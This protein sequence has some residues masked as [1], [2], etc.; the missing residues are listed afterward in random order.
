[1]AIGQRQ[2]ERSHVEQAWNLIRQ[3]AGALIL[4]R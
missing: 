3:E 2:T 4:S 1:M